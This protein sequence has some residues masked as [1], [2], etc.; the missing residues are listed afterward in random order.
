[1]H[2][3]TRK[4]PNY[5]QWS[6]KGWSTSYKIGYQ[7]FSDANWKMLNSKMPEYL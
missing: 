4:Q 5:K 2:T 7:T 6:T 1:M 3:K